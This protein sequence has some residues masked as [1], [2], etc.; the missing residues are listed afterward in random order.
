MPARFQSSDAWVFISINP[1]E[2]G[3]TLEFLIATADWINHAIPTQNEI[4]GAVNR[5][6]QAGLLRVEADKFFL[7]EPGHEIQRSILA[8]KGSMIKLWAKM[9]KHLNET[10]LPVVVADEFHLS[11]NQLEDAHQRYIK[12]FQKTKA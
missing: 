6:A 8:K 4:E 1:S 5:L 12:R 10:E 3:T 9:E 2:A 7:T 11:A